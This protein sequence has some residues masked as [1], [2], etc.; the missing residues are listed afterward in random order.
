MDTARTMA[1]GK[2]QRA[3][4]QP[5]VMTKETVT[6]ECAVMGSSYIAKGV[7]PVAR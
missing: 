6:W 7:R 4:E 5:A 3:R 2:Q 1:E